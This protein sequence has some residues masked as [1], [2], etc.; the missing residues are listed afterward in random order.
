M[1][2]RKYTKEGLPIISK[3]SIDRYTAE[4]HVNG[5][6]RQKLKTLDLGQILCDENR[7]LFKYVNAL[8]NFHEQQ[9]ETEIAKAIITGVGIAYILLRSQAEANKLEEEFNGS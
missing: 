1:E 8:R 3:D 7:E 5:T 6:Y 4:N 2:E 9:G